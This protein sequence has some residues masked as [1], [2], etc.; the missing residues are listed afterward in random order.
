VRL[1]KQI[2]DPSYSA[3]AKLG[4]SASWINL[5]SLACLVFCTRLVTKLPSFVSIF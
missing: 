2:V 5:F 4:G 1:R 3:L